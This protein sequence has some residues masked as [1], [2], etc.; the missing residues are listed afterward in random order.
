VTC[1]QPVRHILHRNCESL[2]LPEC[3]NPF[4]P[5]TICEPENRRRNQAWT[6]AI[7]YEFLLAFD[8]TT[9]K[10]Q[11]STNHKLVREQPKNV[12]EKPK[13]VINREQGLKS[14]RAKRSNLC[15]RNSL[16]QLNGGCFCPK[17][18]SPVPMKSK[19]ASTG[20]SKKS[21]TN[22]YVYEHKRNPSHEIIRLL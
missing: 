16:H 7:F 20:S 5:S 1:C 10:Y 14:G 15:P 12:K 21:K 9:L 4:H 13:P 18:E 6:H 17:P 19:G 3:R 22:Q 8:V 2:S 11:L